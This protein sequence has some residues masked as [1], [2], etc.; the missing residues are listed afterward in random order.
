MKKKMMKSRQEKILK[1]NIGIY[2]LH[3]FWHIS[4][5]F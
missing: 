2:M 4:F 3:L 5:I 1:T